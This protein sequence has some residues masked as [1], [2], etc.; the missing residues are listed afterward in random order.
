MSRQLRAYFSTRSALSFVF[1]FMSYQLKAGAC[2]V[3]AACSLSM[4]CRQLEA[5]PAVGRQLETIWGMTSAWKLSVVYLQLEAYLLCVARMK[6]FSLA[7][8][9]LEAFLWNIGNWKLISVMCLQSGAGSLGSIVSLNL[10]LIVCYQPNAF[11]SGVLSA[12]G[13]SLGRFVSLKLIP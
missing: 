1:S 10:I 5:F 13:L 11:P 2:C 8:R 9:Q 7:Y 12:W 6:F 3:S 4:V